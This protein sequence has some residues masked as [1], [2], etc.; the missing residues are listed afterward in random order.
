[1]VRVGEIVR[2]EMKIGGSWG[3]IARIEIK[4]V[5]VGRDSEIEVMMVRVRAR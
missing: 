5:R 3:E 1:M 4:I 2:I